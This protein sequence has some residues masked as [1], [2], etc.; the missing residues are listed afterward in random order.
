[1]RATTTTPIAHQRVMPPLEAGLVSLIG[2]SIGMLVATARLPGLIV[3]MPNRVG[4]VVF[5]AMLCAPFLVAI[6]L[7]P[8]RRD[9]AG[10]LWLLAAA[11]VA[12]FSLS[13]LMSILTGAAEEKMLTMIG[14]TVVLVIFL[15][16][17]RKLGGPIAT[18]GFMPLL[19]GLQVGYIV[20][21]LYV[22]MTGRLAAEV[23]DEGLQQLGFVEIRGIQRNTVTLVALMALAATLT[24]L[25]TRKRPAWPALA[26]GAVTVALVVF[27]VFRVPGKGA[28]LGAGMMLLTYLI[29]MIWSRRWGMLLTA[30]GIA[31]AAAPLLYQRA[32]TYLMY[33]LNAPE[34]GNLTGRTLIWEAAWRTVESSRAY[35]LGFGYESAFGEAQYYG[36][37]HF[38]NEFVNAL[39]C[40]GVVG[41]ALLAAWIG[42]YLFK[43]SLVALSG[44]GTEDGR[45][46]VFCCLFG[47]F[48]LSRLMAD[49]SITAVIE[50]LPLWFLC[51][52]MLGAA[53]REPTER[54][55]G[56]DAGRWGDLVARPRSVRI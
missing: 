55:A 35:V 21:A 23:L 3:D 45:V 9:E 2:F 43:S 6:A 10:G 52:A 49:V 28:W 36:L 48:I 46:L 4:T 12:S 56:V 8:R 14:G 19:R 20:L 51:S 30:L 54:S 29:L 26:L 38:H 39:Y 33:Y 1:M 17:A 44:V 53:L 32:S 42:V 41:L 37:A 27:I 5:D 50:P 22:L 31:A 18:V 47:V 7:L 11:T 34:S 16:G 40:G 24:D 25:S 15:L 13:T